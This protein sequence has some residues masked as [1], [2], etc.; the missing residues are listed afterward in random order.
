MSPRLQAGD[1]L[2]IPGVQRDFTAG[3]SLA[4]LDGDA[5]VAPLNSWILRFTAEG[6][7]IFATFDWH[8]ADHWSLRE[9][10]GPWPAHCIAGT[11]GAAFAD[12]LELPAGV[13]GAAKATGRDA[14]AYSGF[15]GTDLHRRL[16][17]AGVRRLFVGG[18]ATDCCVLQS[19]LDAR[20]LR[21]AVVVLADVMRAFEH[22]AR[23]HRAAT[24]L[25]ID[26]DDTESAAA[27]L[28]PVM[29]RLRADGNGIQ[30]VRI[31]SGDLR[32]HA[33]CVRATLD[34]HAVAALPPALRSTDDVLAYAVDVAAPL[35][36]MAR[37]IDWQRA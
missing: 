29:Q 10:G 15:S 17:E 8:P 11:H 3:G 25:L 24:T 4:V 27:A 7:P 19:V 20:R 21:Y 28:I 12:D 16:Q 18:L 9:Q 6:L 33:R 34:E 1:A 30:T 35:R 5:V 32:D 31:D 22:F 13:V 23:P 36:Q 14:E 2:Q 26:T 37:Q